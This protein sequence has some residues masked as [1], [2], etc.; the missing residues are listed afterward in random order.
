MVGLVAPATDTGLS[1]RDLAA[2][3]S[4]LLEQ[5]AFRR[6]QLWRIR[7]APT[8]VSSRRHPSA[9]EE[10]QECLAL[11]ARIVLADVEAAL[12]GMDAGHYGRCCDCREA[13][14]LARLRICPQTL[15]C[16]ECHR[17]REQG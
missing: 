8:R 17:V 6:E 16:A 4:G 13:I 3:R 11:G 15:F 10:V 1:R 5:R 14:G 2:L 9:L 12:A 7:Q